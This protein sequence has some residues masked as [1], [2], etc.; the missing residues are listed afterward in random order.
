M[1]RVEIALTYFREDLGALPTERADYENVE[2]DWLQHEVFLTEEVQTIATHDLIEPV[3]IHN[4]SEFSRSRGGFWCRYWYVI[5]DWRVSN[6]A[7]PFTGILSSIGNLFL[8][9]SAHYGLDLSMQ[10]QRHLM[11]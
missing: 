11:V 7:S 2:K 10:Q 6:I 3:A 1:S 5:G 9:I 8:G 4:R